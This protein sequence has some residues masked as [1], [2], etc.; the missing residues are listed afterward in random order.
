MPDPTL[1]PEELTPEAALR[2][3]AAMINRR[4]PSRLA[5]YLA[6]DFHYASQAVYGEL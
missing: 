3:Y 1:E 2:V 6:N 5:P 4:D